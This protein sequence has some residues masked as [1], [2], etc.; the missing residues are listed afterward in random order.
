M[1]DHQYIPLEVKPSAACLSSKDLL[2]KV[3]LLGTQ[4]GCILRELVL[5]SGP[6]RSNPGPGWRF[7]CQFGAEQ[8]SERVGTYKSSRQPFA[9]LG[10]KICPAWKQDGEPVCPSHNDGVRKVVVI[11]CVGGQ[12]SRVGEERLAKMYDGGNRFAR[13]KTATLRALAVA[14]SVGG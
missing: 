12:N 5:Q 10:V 7:L 9:Y 1:N 14:F 11:F 3:R 4:R 13:S 2:P 6:L 8:G